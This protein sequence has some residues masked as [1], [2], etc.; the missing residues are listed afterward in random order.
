VTAVTTGLLLFRF[1]VLAWPRQAE[2]EGSREPSVGITAWAGLLLGILVL[3]VFPTAITPVEPGWHSLAPGKLWSTTAP[4]LAA[5]LIALL[6]RRTRV[7]RTAPM[8]PPGDLLPVLERG[9]RSASAQACRRAA[10]LGVSR[11]SLSGG[12]LRRPKAPAGPLRAAERRL[13][14]GH[15]AGVVIAALILLMFALTLAA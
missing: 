9:L 3:S 5:A 1:L 6:A 8:V 2:R 12:R 13:A 10:A 4:V 15:A 7:R 14:T 11:R